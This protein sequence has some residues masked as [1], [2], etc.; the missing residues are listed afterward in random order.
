MK[1]LLLFLLMC[2]FFADVTHGDV[3][4]N[5]S[6][7]GGG[8]VLAF[9]GSLNATAGDGIPDPGSTARRTIGIQS[10]ASPTFYSVPVGIAHPGSPA[11]TYTG[12]NNPGL[13][14]TNAP[15]YNSIQGGATATGTAFMFRLNSATLGSGTTTIDFWA[16]WGP[17]N[18]PFSGALTLPG[19]SI[20]SQGIVD[21]F[22]IQTSAGNI[23]FST[24]ASA[25]PE[26]SAVAVIGLGAMALGV[27]ASRRKK[28][29]VV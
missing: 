7:T 26:P 12:P 24:T 2:V 11:I 19:E 13:F 6:D 16:D 20:A 1:K 28:K 21:G 3:I 25:V 18:T 17:A 29:Q 22:T 10:L 14:A 27:V 9:S 15:V 4:I 8:L 5:A 23:V